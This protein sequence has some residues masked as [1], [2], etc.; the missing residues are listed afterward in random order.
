[1]QIPIE[2][3]LERKHNKDQLTAEDEETGAGD[4]GED[5]I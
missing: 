2:Y 4:S 1:M 3:Q 5:Q